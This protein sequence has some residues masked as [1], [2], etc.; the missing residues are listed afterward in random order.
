MKLH[1]HGSTYDTPHTEWSVTEGKII[2]KYRGK[3]LKSHVLK[4]QHRRCHKL[5]EFTYR[6]VHYTKG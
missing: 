2:G 4:E 3:P 6:G 1:F 5:S